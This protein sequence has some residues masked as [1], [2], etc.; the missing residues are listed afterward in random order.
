[1]MKLNSMKVL[2]EKISSQ[3]D[4]KLRQ[5][6]TW[7]QGQS[8]GAWQSILRYTLDWLSPELLGTG[9]Q[10]KQISENQ[11]QGY[12]PLHPSNCDFQKEIHPG[13]VTNACFELARIYLQKHMPR[14]YFK[15]RSSTYQLIKKKSWQSALTLNLSMSAEQLDQFFIDLQKN[16][17]AQGHF[18]FDINSPSSQKVGQADLQLLIELTPLIN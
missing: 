4:E 9:F 16:K 14:D 2:K 11:I 5:A 12:L 6:K 13:L 10:M 18:S 3:V 7:S 17:K 15:I 1:M 8:P